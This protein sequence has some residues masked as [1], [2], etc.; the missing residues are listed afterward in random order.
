MNQHVLIAGPA[1]IRCVP[2]SSRVMEALD[3]ALFRRWSDGGSPPT[4]TMELREQSRSPTRWRGL[5]IRGCLDS[6]DWTA[7]YAGRYLRW[8]AK[9]QG[10]QRVRVAVALSGDDA[11]D[12]YVIRS[13]LRFFIAEMLVRRGGVALHAASVSRRE[14]AAVFMAR[15]GG[16]KTTLIGRFGQDGGLG[17]D[18]TMVSRVEGQFLVYPSPLSGREGTAVTGHAAPLWR[19]CEMEKGE[20]TRAERMPVCE[21]AAAILRHAILFTRDVAARQALLDT[22]LRLARA[23]GVVRL[24]QSL[25]TP[26]WEALRDV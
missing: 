19:L 23:V 6:S 22:V 13:F 17:D 18:F 16:G 26:P 11:E 7:R 25:G 15:S 4:C 3:K 5:W 21:Q 20:S 9:G 24:H 14:G 2:A 12:G 8:E 1:R 10:F